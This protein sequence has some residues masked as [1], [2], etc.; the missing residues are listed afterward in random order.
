MNT[1]EQLANYAQDHHELLLLIR[2]TGSRAIGLF[3]EWGSYDV[4][5]RMSMEER[6]R[7]YR[8]YLTPPEDFGL[9]YMVY[10]YQHTDSIDPEIK[11]YIRLEKYSNR[12][13]PFLEGKKEYMRDASPSS[14]DDFYQYI[15]AQR[16]KYHQADSVIADSIAAWKTM[17]RE[18]PMQHPGIA[19]PSCIR[20]TDLFEEIPY[21]PKNDLWG[22]FDE[23]Q[24][25]LQ[26]PMCTFSQFYKMI[27]SFP[28]K[29]EWS[30]SSNECITVY[31]QQD[32]KTHCV[33][34][35]PD[36]AI[37]QSQFQTNCETPEQVI[38]RLN[39]TFHIEL[40][41]QPGNQKRIQ[42]E[43]FLDSSPIQ[44]QQFLYFIYTH[45]IWSRFL[46]VE[47]S[48]VLVKDKTYLYCYYYPN[49]RNP[50]R[51]ITFTLRN[52][53]SEEASRLPCS[54]PRK[55]HSTCL[56]IKIRHCV[57]QDDIYE[58]L[59]VISALVELYKQ[60]IQT[61]KRQ[62]DVKRIPFLTIKEPPNRF[63]KQKNVDLVVGSIRGQQNLPRKITIEEM[64]GKETDYY[65]VNL[66][67]EP[68]QWVTADRTNDPK[69]PDGTDK[70]QVMVF[71]KDKEEE[72][73]FYICDKEAD[74]PY[75]N[76][77][78]IKEL[79]KTLYAPKCFKRNKV[80]QKSHLLK[81]YE[82]EQ[83]RE[84]KVGSRIIETGKSL[85]SKQM[86]FT[87]PWMIR[88]YQ[89]Y[90]M[91]TQ[92]LR[93]GI[94]KS[95]LDSILYVLEACKHPRVEIPDEEDIAAVKATIV[96]LLH[97]DE[98][99]GNEMMTEMYDMK[100]DEYIRQF[101]EGYIDPMMYH[102]L[103]C[104]YYNVHIALFTKK[105][106]HNKDYFFL[107]VPRYRMNATASETYPSTIGIVLN[108]GNEFNLFKYP[109]AELLV[110]VPNEMIT[111]VPNGFTFSSPIT[112]EMVKWNTPS[113]LQYITKTEYEM[114]GKTIDKPIPLLT[115]Q[116]QT[117]NEYGLVSWFHT[118][119]GSI[120]CK[121]PCHSQFLPL[122]TGD[123]QLWKEE[124]LMALNQ[125]A[126]VSQERHIEYYS[127]FKGYRIYCN[128]VEYF[129][130]MER[131]VT[132]SLQD[133]RFFEKTSRYLV[134][135]VCFHF[136]H[137][138]HQ[139]I[140]GT[141]KTD[142]P[143]EP[144][145]KGEREEVVVSIAQQQ[146][147]LKQRQDEIERK[148]QE[149]ESRITVYMN[150]FA[151]HFFT[152]ISQPEHDYIQHVLDVKR[153]LHL[154]NPFYNG[155]TLHIT[156]EYIRKKLM[157]V[158][159][160][161]Y[162]IKKESLLRYYTEKK[163]RH[164]YVYAWDCIQYPFHHIVTTEQAYHTY[165]TNHTKTIQHASSRIQPSQFSSYLLHVQEPILGHTKWL[166]KRVS[167]INEAFI[168]SDH[169]KKYHVLKK[170]EADDEWEGDDDGFHQ[171]VWINEY[172]Y[173]LYPSLLHEPTVAIPVLSIINIEQDRAIVQVMLAI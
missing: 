117:I 162:H 170:I 41:R 77:T 125:R 13:Q 26:V 154:F 48:R 36:N 12:L 14:S 138:V 30:V 58:T 110:Q 29:K 16:N 7:I 89:L 80:A 31:L 19:Y 124:D 172:E 8:L 63:T 88:W 116:S 121:T 107:T 131:I 165:V 142:G 10:V 104:R 136:S 34:L 161:E 37:I 167:S 123:I 70:I 39:K 105:G 78:E 109:I 112:M 79:S 76:V 45:P 141:K 40:I 83:E 97:T 135:Y 42:A 56:R 169:W 6:Y 149:I 60:Q 115:V 96:Q 128:G 120:L 23:A 87:Q 49:P 2:W 20:I 73:H 1:D 86:A 102:S 46:F 84:E 66:A 137:Y 99:Y 126:I 114:Y 44:L 25:S 173:E 62:F 54:I 122:Y 53:F 75:V 153:D 82:E 100:R 166:M 65:H 67:S 90:D 139:F 38:D 118:S 163:M 11:Q 106:F 93:R 27:D 113:L 150:D 85:K 47:E 59:H 133:Y 33:Y 158:L 32:T 92:L 24:L 18:Q 146:L 103:L 91:K 50:T 69:H 155:K 147:Q 151:Q 72:Q 9:Y 119:Q 5:T 35:H 57:N 159:L 168:L 157:Y 160:N 148:K 129:F 81:T 95:P 43:C 64:K 71:P 134:E 28:V 127:T 4:E 22:M 164:F 140:H 68:Y 61:I 132:S 108:Q 130:P 52:V 145:E 94:S 171:V 3:E 98:R 152:I 74:F 51:Y 143:D 55:S 21:A 156:S 101:S 144:D 15:V 111:P 17:L